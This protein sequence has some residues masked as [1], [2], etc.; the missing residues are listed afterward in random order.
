MQ[1]INP[2]HAQ[3]CADKDYAPAAKFKHQ[4]SEMQ[5][6][7]CS[8]KTATQHWNLSTYTAIAQRPSPATNHHM[9]P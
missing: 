6:L 7:E 4:E 9:K 5:L 1:T 2:M 8:D 3:E